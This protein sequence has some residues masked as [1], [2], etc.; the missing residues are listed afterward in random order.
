MK[1]IKTLNSK[2][3]YRLLKLIYIFFFLFALLGVL[4]II[5]S[6][7]YLSDESV[8]ENLDTSSSEILEEMRLT[9]PMDYTDQD[10]RF[11]TAVKELGVEQD[12]AFEELYKQ[13]AND[14]VEQIVDSNKD[15]MLLKSKILSSIFLIALLASIF[16]ILRRSFYYV[17]LGTFRITGK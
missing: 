12:V 2:A 10:I 6:N 13:K 14:K 5:W 7:S 9:A 8:L 4:I 3:W 17:I 16:E 15:S 11:L 1:T